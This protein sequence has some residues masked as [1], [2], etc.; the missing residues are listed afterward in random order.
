[1]RSTHT[2]DRSAYEAAALAGDPIPGTDER[3]E[4]D[5]AVGEAI[6][7][8]LRTCEGVDVRVFRERYGVDVFTHYARSVAEFAQNGLLLV[9]DRGFRLTVRGR[10]VANDVCAAFLV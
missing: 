6:M 9:D 8:A 5:A 1:M 4:G 10:F 2:R 7:L 3:L